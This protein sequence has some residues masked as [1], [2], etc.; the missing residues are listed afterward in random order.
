MLPPSPKK[1]KKDRKSKSQNTNTPNTQPQQD[2]VR[3]YESGGGF[4]AYLARRRKQIRVEKKLARSAATAAGAPTKWYPGWE[5]DHK[6]YRQQ[7]Q[8][9]QERKK[10]S[11]S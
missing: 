3:V 7:Q 4:L 6:E 5:A 11:S 9:Q 2:P 10:S 1:E 8:Q